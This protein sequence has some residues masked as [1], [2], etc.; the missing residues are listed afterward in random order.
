M[1]E[2]S[3]DNLRESERRCYAAAAESQSREASYLLLHL[4]GDLC[5]GKKEMGK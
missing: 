2:V 1:R 4:E 5:E 3:L